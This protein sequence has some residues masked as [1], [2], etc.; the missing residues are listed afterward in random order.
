MPLLGCRLAAA[1]GR[2]GRYAVPALLSLVSGCANPERLAA[3][4]DDLTLEAVV[5]DLPDVRY[6]AD[7]DPEPFI[8][9]AMQAL[10]RE[11]TLLASSGHSGPLPPA[12]FLAVSGGGEDGAFAAGLLNGWTE[13]GDRPKFKGVTG[14]S[15]GALIAPMAFLGPE[16]DAELRDAYITVTK[17]DIFEERGLTAA[18]FDD[19]LTDTTPMQ[20]LIASIVTPEFMARIAEEHEK[21]RLLLIATTDLDARRPVIWN[22]TAIA[23]S[24]Q[25]SALELFRKILLASAAVP[26]AFPPVMID[27]EAGGQHYQ[28]MHVDGGAMAQVF[29]YPPSIQVAELSQSQNIQRQRVLYMIRNARLDADWASVERNT[30]SIA[31]RAISS[32]IQSQGIGDLYRIY[33]TTQRDGFD[34]NLAYIPSSFDTPQLEPFDTNYM[35]ALFELGYQLARNGYPWEKQPP[36]F[37]TSTA[38]PAQDAADSNE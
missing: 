36:G 34:Y 3:V 14:V 16:Y 7:A 32:L 23:A 31:G 19:A 18:I 5:P 1:F 35:N 13:A 28:E 12:Y 8:R 27:V 37:G 38:V 10:Q 15:T 25:P 17:D 21:G 11:Q 26:G 9:A 30:L 33:L 6:W 2:V 24:G 29:L 22:M 20:R 4:P